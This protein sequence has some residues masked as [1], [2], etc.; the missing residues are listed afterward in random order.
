MGTSSV[1]PGAELLGSC[2]CGR[3]RV[4]LP[5]DSVG[6]V[7]CHCTDCQRLHGN[8]FAMLV[9]KVDEVRWEGEG[10]V[11]WYRSSPTAERGFCAECGSRIAKRP[12]EGG[13]VMVSAGLFDPTLSRT[14]IKNVW[15]EQKPQWYAAPQ[16]GAMSPED[17]VALALAAP[18]ES[19]TAQYGY[20]LR[21]AS[22]NGKPPGLIALTWIA[23]SDAAERER[24]RAHSRENVKD[25]LAE[26]G[27]ISI[28]TG[29]TGLRGFTV[30]AWED[31][32]SMRRALGKH[33]AVA[34]KELFGERFV[35]SVWTSV[36]TPT[37][38][39]R[40]WVRCPACG[41]LEDVSDDHR[42][43]GECRAPLPER[44]AFW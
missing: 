42:G 39:N 31:E 21:A 33:H 1:A 38:I 14:L 3:V 25:F 41:S 17:F 7:A 16:A 4:H 10:H 29:F 36:W 44:P 26:P 28:V 19:P 12:L 9:A 35:A 40:I 37:R 22:G 11:R 30:T 27:F 18:I 23:A 8:F 5:P 32:S 2:H 20:S 43:C 13:K 24:I 34:M 6:V 15:L